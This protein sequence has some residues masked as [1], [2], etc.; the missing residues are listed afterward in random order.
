MR[1]IFVIFEKIENEIWDFSKLQLKKFGD[2]REFI[3]FRKTSKKI[4]LQK[5]ET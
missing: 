3:Y 4:Q 2:L 5:I 1:R